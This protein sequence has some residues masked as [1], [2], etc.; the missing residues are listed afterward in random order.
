MDDSLYN[1]IGSSAWHSKQYIIEED[2][3]DV[4]NKIL[5]RLLCT[6]RLALGEG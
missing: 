5:D 6:L 3:G 2:F 4:E 1:I